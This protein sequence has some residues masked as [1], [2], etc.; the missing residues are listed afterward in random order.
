MNNDKYWQK[1]SL[2]RLDASEKIGLDLLK[3]LFPI[4]DE[5][6]RKIDKDIKKL[7]DNYAKKGILDVK[8]LKRTLTPKERR[9][10]IKAVE[11]ACRKL[12]LNPSDVFDNRYLARLTRLQAIKDQINTEIMALSPRSVAMSQSALFDVASITYATIQEDLKLLG[13][14]PGFTKLNKKVAEEILRSRWVGGNYSSR[15]WKNTAEFAK[16]LPTTIGSALTSGQSYAKTVAILR[17]RFDVAKSDATRLVVTETNYIHNQAEL[18]SYIDDGYT[19]YRYDAFLD[20]R[21]SSICRDLNNDVFK[22]ASATPGKNYPPMHPRCRSTTQ[23]IISSRV[24]SD[25]INRT[26]RLNTGKTNSQIEK[27]VVDKFAN[28]VGR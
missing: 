14:Q 27:Q 1:R 2:E 10:F 26:S 15:I 24:D 11:A 6:K 17:E 18:Q 20:S 13:A 28:S 23:V 3:S 9:Q 25:S 21:T 5:A 22:V 8:L 12:G 16:E 4:Y 19:E 7:F